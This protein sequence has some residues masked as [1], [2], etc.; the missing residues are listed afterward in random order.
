MDI[1]SDAYPKM[2]D[3][4]ESHK[5]DRSLPHYCTEL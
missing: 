2:V 3:I 5:T 4:I 1:Y